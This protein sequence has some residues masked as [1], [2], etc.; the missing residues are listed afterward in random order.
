MAV[1]PQPGQTD[2][3]RP[4]RDQRGQPCRLGLRV[5]RLAIDLMQAGSVAERFHEALPQVTPKL[6]G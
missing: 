1:L 2:I 3:H 4:A 6:A 5:R